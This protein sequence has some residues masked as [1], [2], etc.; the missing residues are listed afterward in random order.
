MWKNP[1]IFDN[2]LLQEVPLNH[3]STHDLEHLALVGISGQFQK[4]T[5]A[6]QY[7]LD[8]NITVWG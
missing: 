2:I 3:I 8:R 4:N 5:K 7:I 1:H 6:F